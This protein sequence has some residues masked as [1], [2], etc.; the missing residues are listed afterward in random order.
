M[1]T[2]VRGVTYA[3]VRHTAQSLDVSEAAV[4]SALFR[5]RMELLGLGNTKRKPVT[6]E[7]LSFRSIAEAARALGLSEKY[8]AKVIA[9]D[10]IVG[11]K[12][13]RAAALAYKE[14]MGVKE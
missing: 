10:S 12:R 3:S 2:K 1:I 4:Y 14:K 8:V 13:F 5:G 11:M 7:G 9:T 6:V